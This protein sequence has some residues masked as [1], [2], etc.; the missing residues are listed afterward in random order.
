MHEEWVD[1]TKIHGINSWC[2]TS[3]S[4]RDSTNKHT[5]YDARYS[6]IAHDVMQDYASKASWIQL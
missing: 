1:S 2:M 4:V 3:W 6:L 5:L